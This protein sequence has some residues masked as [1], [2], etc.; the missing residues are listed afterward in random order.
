MAC[1][2]EKL[3]VMVE[4]YNALYVLSH[5][6]YY[7]MIMKESIWEEISGHL[8]ERDVYKRQLLD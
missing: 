4:Q 8:N 2:D 3:I 7:N 5:K 6:D 1:A